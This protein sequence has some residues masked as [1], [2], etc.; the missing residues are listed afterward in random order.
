MDKH[1]YSS[2][3]ITWAQAF[4][5]ALALQLLAFSPILMADEADS[6]GDDANK[7]VTISSHFGQDGRDQLIP[8]KVTEH[9]SAALDGKRDAL[10][11]G[12]RSAQAAT[13][14][15]E[16]QRTINSDFWFFTADVILFG[17]VDRDGYY[18]GID[19]LFDADTIYSFADVF[20]V[21]YLSEEGGPWEEYTETE[22][23]EIRGATSDDEYV[24]VTDLVSGY[25]TGSYD[26]LIELYDAF[27]GAF[28]AEIGPADTSELAFLPL[29]DEHRDEPFSSPH[30]VV[31]THGGGGSL[32]VMTFAVLASIA[33][34]SAGAGAL[35]RRRRLHL[36]TVSRRRGPSS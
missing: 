15:A 24:I 3:T 22:V 30:T 19:L 10:V 5:W 8:D 16:T 6:N 31:V 36:Q 4:A 9:E 2:E 11:K 27:D 33:I 20:A 18:T 28:V 35:R 25:P 23:F 14:G 7:R 26:I 12:Q 1:R 34:V 32:D 21:V 13:G 29:E 17:D